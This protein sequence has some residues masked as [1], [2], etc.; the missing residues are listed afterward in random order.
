MKSIIRMMKYNFDEVIDRTGTS[1][2]KID[3]LQSRFGANDILPLWVADMDFRS[4]DFVMDAIRERANHEVLGYTIRNKEWYQPI[5]QWIKQKHNWHVESN[6]IGYVPGILPGIVLAMQTFTQPGDKIVIQPPIYPPFMSMVKNNDRQIVYNQLIQ[7]D[8]EI[9]MDLENLKQLID[10]KTKMLLLCSPH[11]P[12]G[13][14]WTKEEL[15]ALL[16][17]CK[18]NNIL[19]ISDEIHADLVLPGNT[20]VPFPTISEDAANQCITFMAP[21]KTFNI[22]GL[23]SASFIIPNDELRAKFR[24]KVEAAEIGGG[25]IFA[26]VATKAA[27]ENGAEWLNQ[28]V[29]YIQENVNYVDEYLKAHLPKIK[30]FIPQASFLIWLD[31]SKL[32][33]SD[34]EIRKILIQKAKLGFNHGPSFG[35]G[36]EGYQRMNVG[37]SRLVIEEAMKRLSSA[38]A[39]YC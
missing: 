19:V 26:S 1:T 12:G 28:L 25:N 27:Y 22:A 13:R 17:I 29:H 14:V 35:P 39:Q 36:G 8:G 9:R 6:W 16:E 18:E 5:A 33:M 30:A 34:D 31:F 4:P 37:C 23:A 32:G 7:K 3:L 20:H 24:L 2:Y 15:L 11:N 38:F 21:S 10:E